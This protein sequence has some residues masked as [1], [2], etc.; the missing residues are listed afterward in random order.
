MGADRMEEGADVSEACI[1]SIF[2]C[3]AATGSWGRAGGGSVSKC[4]Y[5]LRTRAKVYRVFCLGQF[6]NL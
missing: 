6:L 2:E 5:V 1:G 4:V 3:V